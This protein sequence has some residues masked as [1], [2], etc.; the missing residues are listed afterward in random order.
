MLDAMSR[1]LGL[2]VAVLVLLPSSARSA[3]VL[4]DPAHQDCRA[5]L[6]SFDSLMGS[7]GGV[8]AQPILGRAADVWGYAPSY[9]LSAAISSLAVPFLVL[10]RRARSEADV[11]ADP[12][13]TGRAP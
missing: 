13:A 10:A 7:A 2:V 8:W 1:I 12:K 4:C 6:L 9:V 11:Y 5:T 3:E